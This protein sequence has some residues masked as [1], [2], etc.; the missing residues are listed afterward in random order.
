M[1]NHQKHS[2]DRDRYGSL[3]LLFQ[4]VRLLAN[5]RHSRRYIAGHFGIS[6]KTVQRYFGLIERVGIPLI[7][8]TDN[9]DLA[10][11]NKVAGAWQNMYSVDRQWFRKMMG[12]LDE[13]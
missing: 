1:P 13:R 12:K 6:I 11:K 9:D 10:D 5:Q 2:L 7:C 3:V 8:E 4:M